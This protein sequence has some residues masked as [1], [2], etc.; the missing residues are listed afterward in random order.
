MSRGVTVHLYSALLRPHLEYWVQFWAPQFKKDKEL[1][2]TVQWGYRD[3]EGTE[4]SEKAEGAG[5]VQPGEAE[6]GYY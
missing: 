2:E 3:S 4:A 1:L 6:R 5:F